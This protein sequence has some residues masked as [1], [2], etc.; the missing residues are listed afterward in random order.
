MAY[1]DIG[2][3]VSGPAP[4]KTRVRITT[5]TTAQLM[6]FFANFMKL[7]PSLKPFN[8]DCHQQVASL[9]CKPN[10]SLKGTPS[11]NDTFVIKKKY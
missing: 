5:N 3:A 7:F 11:K 9:S 1:G 2:G 8:S 6:F 4:V 10:W